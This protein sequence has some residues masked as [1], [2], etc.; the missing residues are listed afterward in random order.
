MEKIKIKK[1]V[2]YWVE[3]CPICGNKITGTSEFQTRYNLKLH[4]DAHKRKKKRDAEKA[5]KVKK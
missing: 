5:K 3:T 4:L 2:E 1:V